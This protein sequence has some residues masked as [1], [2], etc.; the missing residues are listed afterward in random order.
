MRPPEN[1]SVMAYTR[2]V[3]LHGYP[4]RNDF[5]GGSH[6][7]FILYKEKYVFLQRVYY[8]K[9]RN[10]KIRNMEDPFFREW[11]LANDEATFA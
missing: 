6:Y 5:T 10:E 7:F 9:N 4:L 8:E 1:G 2:G 3:S 11:V